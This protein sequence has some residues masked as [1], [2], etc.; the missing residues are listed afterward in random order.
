MMLDYTFPDSDRLGT[1]APHAGIAVGQRV[2][3]LRGLALDHALASSFSDYQRAASC[4]SRSAWTGPRSRAAS[5]TSRF[6][7]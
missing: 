7:W 5:T 4:R 2:P 3:E 1:L 6:R